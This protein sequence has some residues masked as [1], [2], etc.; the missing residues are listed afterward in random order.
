MFCRASAE[1]LSL[2]LDGLLEPQ[3]SARLDTHLQT[4]AGCRATWAA[5]READRVLRVG[6]RRPIPPPVDFQARVMQRV[7]ATPVARPSLW[8]RDRQQIRGGRPTIRL[9]PPAAISGHRVPVP[10][11]IAAAPLPRAGLA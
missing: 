2:R 9:S 6:A 8:E 7:A 10:A 4:C 1:L 5:L 11:G 3:D